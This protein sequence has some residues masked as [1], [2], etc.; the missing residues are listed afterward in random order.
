MQRGRKIATARREQ[1]A[2]ALALHGFTLLVLAGWWAYSQLVPAYL[3]PGPVP[4][5]RRMGAFIGDAQLALQLAIS[6]GHV[7]S[8][9]TLAVAVGATIA[10]AVV[11]TF[12]I[13]KV[14][15]LILGIRVS[16]RDEE[17]GIDLATHGEVA[18]QG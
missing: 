2:R 11:T 4:V 16:A 13:V 5:L 10:Y 7:A 3:L 15:D 6:L 1:T 9:I 12:V 14:V 18:Y 17:I 8:A